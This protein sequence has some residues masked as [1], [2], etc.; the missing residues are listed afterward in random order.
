MKIILILSGLILMFIGIFMG[1]YANFNLGI[2]LTAFLG[3]FFFFWGAFYEKLKEICKNGVMKYLKYTVTGGISLFLLL[4]VFLFA[5]GNASTTD[6]TEDAVIV[7][8]AGIRGESVTY[9]LQTRLDGTVKYYK[10]NPSS[11]IVVSGG[12]GSQEDI[13]EAE[14]MEKYLISEGIPKKKIIK[15]DKAESTTQNLMFSKILLDERFGENNYKAVV[16]TNDFH[17]FRAEWIADKIGLNASHKGTA[18]QL[19]SYP[20]NYIRE[21]LA[22]L[23]TLIFGV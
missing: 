14:A 21:A 22:V 10:K 19:Y 13:T 9:P 16:I 2:L 12:K 20:P 18:V 3:I 15:E 11:V 1:I 23:K 6:Y 5:Y 4:C 17:C 8:G 7:L